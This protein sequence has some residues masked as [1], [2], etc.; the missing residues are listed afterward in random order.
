MTLLIVTNLHRNFC[1]IVVSKN[2]LFYKNKLYR[3][4]FSSLTHI[5]LY[6]RNKNG[7]FIEDAGIYKVIEQIYA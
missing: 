1:F 7:K 3:F 5:R 4:G 6:R 2:F